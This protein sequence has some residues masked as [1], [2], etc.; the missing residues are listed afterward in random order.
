MASRPNRLLTTDLA[1]VV[2]VAETVVIVEGAFRAVSLVYPI[3]VPIILP[4]LLRANGK[5]SNAY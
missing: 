4:D 3:L 2:S 5:H 1:R